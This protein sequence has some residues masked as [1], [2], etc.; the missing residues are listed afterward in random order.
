MRIFLLFIF[1]ISGI[2]GFSQDFFTARITPILEANK[3]L[4]EI[5]PN[6]DQISKLDCPPKLTDKPYDSFSFL[7]SLPLNAQFEE[8]YLSAFLDEHCLDFYQIMVPYQSHLSV[9]QKALKNQSLPSK[10][11]ILP[12]TLSGSNP[13]LKYLK[14]KSGAWQLSFVT[15]RKYGLE[16]TPF[17]DER[18]DISKS[19]IAAAAYLQ[20]LTEYYHNNELLVVTAFY[21]SVPFVNKQIHQLDSVSP[22]QFF[23]SLPNDVKEYYS[24]VKAWS[25]WLEHFDVSQLGTIAPMANLHTIKSIQPTDTISFATISKFMD[26]SESKLWMMNPAFV[27]RVVLPNYYGVFYLPADKAELFQDKYEEFLTFQKAEEE[28]RK[29]ELAKLR[30]EME[31]GIPDLTKNK[32]ITYTVKS[33]DV[34]GKIADR[35]NVKVSQIK[36][37]N[38]L[39]SDRIDIGQKLVLYVPINSKEHKEETADNKI[40]VAASKPIPGKGKPEIYTVKPGESLWSISQKYP[41]VSAENI[42]EWNGVSDKINPGQKLKIYEA[43]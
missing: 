28:K 14:D 4:I 35:N 43:E 38:N 22:T 29:L 9:Y 26:I 23:E 6:A 18:N 33:G 36:Q 5:Y 15:A 1:V 3:Q 11:A 21:T 30:K 41:G 31:Q 16:I 8:T 12:L 39:R 42:M 24:Y 19:S 17:Y 32:A 34:L 37:W 20:F 25:N 40:V 27:G 7:D 10:Y 13:T 2:S